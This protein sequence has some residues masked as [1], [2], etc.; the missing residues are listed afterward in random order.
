MGRVR[1][2]GRTGSMR[3]SRVFQVRTTSSSSVASVC[4][5]TEGE[6]D[7]RSRAQ[8]IELQGRF[9]Q[10]YQ[11]WRSDL[12]SHDDHLEDKLQAERERKMKEI[13]TEIED[14]RQ[15]LDEEKDLERDAAI[16]EFKKEELSKDRA[17][18]RIK[19]AKKSADV[20]L[21]E[22]SKKKE[23]ELE[24]HMLAYP[25]RLYQELYN[26]FVDSQIQVLQELSSNASVRV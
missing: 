5:S 18:V 6:G 22:F 24:R 16:A 26:S 1:R 14:R 4:S 17:E 2:L 15:K 10:L 19:D 9:E 8:F 3:R 7:G 21:E 11:R 12:I 23:R 20:K 25:K 13:E